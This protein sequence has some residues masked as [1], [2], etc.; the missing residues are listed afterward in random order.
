MP[1]NSLAGASLRASGPSAQNTLTGISS[2][3]KNSLTAQVHDRILEMIIQNPSGEQQVLNEKK[4]MESLGVSKAPVR[5]ALIRLCSE[6]VLVCIPR[7]GYVV[8]QLTEKECREITS[9]RI[10]LEIEALRESFAG[11]GE[12]ELGHLRN[13]IES[14]SADPTVSVWKIWEDNEQFHL[15]LASFSENSILQKV[16]GEL[17]NMD[18]RVYAQY[19]WRMKSS[20]SCP[21]DNSS[22]KEIIEALSRKDRK[23][24]EKLL[25]DDIR[26]AV[27][28]SD[29][30][31]PDLTDIAGG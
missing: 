22:H 30:P 6:G 29:M 15:L 31:V 13:Q 26:S 25:V 7:F 28:L 1:D 2:F 10:M 9:L 16:L 17:I 14:S 21:N 23:E 12:Y 27:G 20:L 4:L 18:K 8:V 5:E 11:I 19:I 3:A 24:A